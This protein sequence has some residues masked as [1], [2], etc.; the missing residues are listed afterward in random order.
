MQTTQTKG[1]ALL[2]D[3]SGFE[4]GF[5]RSGEADLLGL[6]LAAFSSTLEAKSTLLPLG[7][8]EGDT[9]LNGAGVRV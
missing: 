6:D 9:G 5:S 8:V 7:G 2:G 3:E 4:K 1:S